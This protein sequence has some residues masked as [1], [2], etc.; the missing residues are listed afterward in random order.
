MG[1]DSFLILDE[2]RSNDGTE[3][4]AYREFAKWDIPGKVLKGNFDGLSEKRNY[5]L[6]LPETREGLADTDYLFIPQSD[7]PP[8]GPLDK[9][10]LTAQVYMMTVCDGEAGENFIPMEWEMPALI[11]VDVPHH[12]EGLV[13]E[14]LMFDEPV[15]AHRLVSPIM[16]RYGSLAS[17][18]QREAQA[19]TLE[20]ELAKEDAP[21]TAFYLAQTYQCLGRDDDAIAMYLHRATLFGGYDQEQYVAMY[22]VGNLY[23][24]K[25]PIKAA[26]AYLDAWS[27]R[28]NRKE[29][30]FHLAHIC[31][32]WGNHESALMFANQALAMTDTTDTMFVER[33]IE[34]WGIEFQWSV[35][36]W[37]C[38]IPEA[39]EV[40]DRLLARDD[41][42]QTH[43][44]VIIANKAQ[45]PRPPEEKQPEVA[46]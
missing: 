15:I 7:E 33:W 20:E 21:R 34:R 37:W 13:H 11:R 16:R 10:S 26:R 45:P 1:V 19:R 25:N 41:I 40:W 5:L 39:Y 36:A 17:T 12:W 22:R 6:G 31:N 29:P 46:A 23:E 38:R 42:P 14:L 30:L 2:E 44:D 35:A 3:E 18:E 28:P 4:V 8:K 27:L 32:V 24:A 9:D 43:R